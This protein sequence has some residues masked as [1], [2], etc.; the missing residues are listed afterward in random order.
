MGRV[1]LC[2]RNE[3]KRRELERSLPGWGIELLDADLPEEEGQSYY[4]NAR[5]KAVFGRALHPGECLLGEDSG[6]EVAALGGEPGLHSARWSERPIEELLR[7]LEGET[8]REAC[9]ICELVLLEPDGGEAR[10]TGVLEGWI[11]EEPRGSEGFGYDPIFIP[12]GSD[13]GS[14][15]GAAVAELG[16]DWKSRNSHR[17]RAARALLDLLEG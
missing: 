14:D 11:A 1:L 5:A 6:L 16:D 9:Y 12:A 17:A 4:E 10:G 7:R 8:A 13:P 3:H 15:P 2:S